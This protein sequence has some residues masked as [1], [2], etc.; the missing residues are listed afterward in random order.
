MQRMTTPLGRF[1]AAFSGKGRGF[2]LTLLFGC[3][4]LGAT[5]SFAQSALPRIQQSDITY[6][7]AFALPT[8]TY[9]TSSFN[10][11]GHGIT[12]YTDPSSGKTTLFMEGH[13]Q[14]PGHVA[15]V[16]VPAS[17][18]KSSNRSSLPVAKVLQNFQ[19]VTDGRLSSVDPSNTSN[20]TFVYGLLAYNNKLI[21][22]AS[23]SY[24][25]SQ[26]ASHGVSGLTLSTSGDFKGFYAMSATAPLRAVGGPMTLIPVEWQ[27]AFGGP[28]LTGECCISV[29]SSTS[30]GPAATVFNP[31]NIGSGNSVSGT[32]VLYYPLANP[33]CGSVGCEASQNEV[34][35]L[36]TRLGGMAFPA[37]SRS[38]LFIG[39][40]GTGRY[41]Y[42]TAAA[43]SNDT[44][45]PDVKG[46]HAQPYRYQIWAYDAN[47]LVAVKN[48]SKQTYAPKPYAVWELNGMPNSSNPTIGGAGYDPDTGRLYITQDYY[49][50]PRV[51]VYQITAS[52][53]AAVKPNPPTN[54]LI[55]Q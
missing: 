48:G 43:C 46:P 5:T 9:G 7:G 8:A 1:G 45:L 53:T 23:N 39:A 15:Q 6:L 19:D 37:G 18:V 4:C 21:V 38:V 50:Q 41:C 26:Q 40:H 47:D 35:N 13:A 55:A 11:G 29:I 36:T 28:A 16:E 30:S 51:E 2:F 24:S 49:D 14:K 20:A 52:G 27:S 34:F 25:A 42:G 54:I 10:Y 32:T 17:L 31:D 33:V 44:N 12:P 22:G 3:S